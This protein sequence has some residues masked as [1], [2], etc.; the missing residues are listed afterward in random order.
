[1]IVNSVQPVVGKDFI[2]DEC[3]QEGMEACQQSLEYEYTQWVID[4]VAQK[5]YQ[6]YLDNRAFISVFDRSVSHI[7]TKNSN[8]NKLNIRGE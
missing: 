3:Y 7:L 1:M 4:P 2:M 8:K 6:L 5:E